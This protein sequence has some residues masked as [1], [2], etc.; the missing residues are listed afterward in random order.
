MAWLE[1]RWVLVVLAELLVRMVMAWSSGCGLPGS[2]RLVRALG[3]GDYPAIPLLEAAFLPVVCVYMRELLA[4]V[5]ERAC[6]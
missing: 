2:S 3:A 5:G 1:W 4:V 6:G